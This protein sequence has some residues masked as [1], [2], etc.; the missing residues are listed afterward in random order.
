MILHPRPLIYVDH[1]YFKL[2]CKE[3][4][5][6]LILCKHRCAYPILGRVDEL[7]GLLL[8][9]DLLKRDERPEELFLLRPHAI[10]RIGY[11]SGLKEAA[12]AVLVRVRIATEDDLAAHVH[13]VLADLLELLDVVQDCHG[14]DIGGVERGVSQVQFFEGFLGE[15]VHEFPVDLFVYVDALDGVSRLA[16]VI[17]GA[18]EDC[19]E[20]EVHVAVGGNVGA[21]VASKVELDVDEVVVG[22][23]EV[24][25]VSGGKGAHED[26]IVDIVLLVLDLDVVGVSEEAQG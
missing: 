16:R 23:V 22:D 24:D 8:V 6:L 15:F 20:G 3:L 25:V 7:S 1:A 19:L 26:D 21:V 12:V 11:Y 10:V 13:A 4:Y 18:L 14:A 5:A 9:L 2:L 17:V